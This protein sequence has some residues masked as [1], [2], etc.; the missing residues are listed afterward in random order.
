MVYDFHPLSIN[1]HEK[2]FVRPDPA[3]YNGIRAEVLWSYICQ[4]TGAIN[5][6]HSS[7]LAVRVIEASKI[8]L[9][10]QNRFIDISLC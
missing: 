5:A 9:T 1:L 6:I 3:N 4:L 8:L 7:G 2:Y 10:G